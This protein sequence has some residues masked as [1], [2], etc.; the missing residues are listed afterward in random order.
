MLSKA[1]SSKK[2]DVEKT[3]RIDKIYFIEEYDIDYNGET[4]CRTTSN[5]ILRDWMPPYTREDAQSELEYVLERLEPQERKVANPKIV[6]FVRAKS[7]EKN[8]TEQKAKHRK[9]TTNK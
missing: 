8:K 7:K 1:K 5:P 6:E 9:N 3:R 4:P 2:H